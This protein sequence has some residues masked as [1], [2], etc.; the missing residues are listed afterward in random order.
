MNVLS[1]IP[2]SIY[3]LTMVFIW[4]VTMAAGCAH[5]E[6]QAPSTTKLVET[7][8]TTE[9]RGYVTD[10][11]EDLKITL[12]IDPKNKKA[13]E[14]LNRL[15]AK[16]T[17]EA[18]VHYRAGTAILDSNAQDAR[19]EFLNALRLRPNYE[20]AITALRNLQLAT[21]EAIIHARLKKE[22]AHA[23]TPVKHK[24]SSD[25]EE[26]DT[27]T[28]SLDIA[29]AAFEEGEYVKAIREFSKM[30]ARYPDDPDIQAY[31]DRSW[32]SYGVEQ[33]NKKNYKKALDSFLKVPKNFDTVGEYIAK[34]RRA[35]KSD[36]SKKKK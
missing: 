11:V 36:S 19:K 13:R 1:E 26:L 35:L 4:V 30:K 22:A 24:L 8:T 21:A 34:C 14:E 18:E 3:L 33:F 2:H 31:L 5:V 23:A 28:Y 12:A 9:K 17:S 6:K 32:Y 15:I 25:E 27:Q 16:R 10:D 20:E 29:V 7:S